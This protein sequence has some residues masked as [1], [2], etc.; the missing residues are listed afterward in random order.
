MDI[1]NFSALPSFRLDG[2]LALIT[3]ASEGIGNSLAVAFARA[4]ANLALI[5]R[6][7][8][9]LSKTIDMVKQFGIEAHS[10]Q[11][12]IRNIGELRQLGISVKKQLGPVV[13]LV[14]SAGYPLTKPALMVTEEDWDLVIDTSL[15]GVFFMCQHFAGMMSEHGYGKIINL[16]STYAQNVAVGKSV[17]AI[18]KNGVSHLT[19]SLAV[20]WAPYGI[21]VNSLAPCL[22][23]TH[24]RES[25]FKD[26]KRIKL[27]V[28]RIP[29]G[30]YAN[31]DDLIG[32]ALFLAS[33]ASDFV[34][35]HTL[36]IDGGR[37]AAG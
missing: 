6:D 16:S 25:V 10:F 20:E 33:E 11:A 2:R 31:T 37:T 17:Y 19:R 32:G 23:K 7:I 8:R 9:R 26:K 12:D 30:R 14:N 24:T 13:I 29:L 27:L 15:K 28:E 5:S 36:F 34:T 22:T 3:G 1:G 4:G 21:R 18:A 35:G